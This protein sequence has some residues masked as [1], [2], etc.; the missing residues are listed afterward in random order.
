VLN[1]VTNKMANDLNVFG[2]LVE[3]VVVRN[4]D[5]TLIITMDRISN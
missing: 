1:K 2:V 3:N 5:S 4:V